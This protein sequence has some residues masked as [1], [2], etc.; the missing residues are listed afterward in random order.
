MKT[1]FLFAGAVLMLVS[2]CPLRAVW[3]PGLLG[4]TVGGNSINKTAF[5][6]E[7]NSYPNPHAGATTATPPWALFT[8]WIYWG[9]IYLPATNIWFAENIDDGI[10]MRI[11]DGATPTIILEDN[12]NH[13]TPTAGS[14]TAPVAGWYPVEIRM[15]NGVGGAGP[16]ASSG[17]TATKGFGY[18]LGGA[19]ST[20]G[21]DYTFPDGTGDILFRYDD[22]GNDV[23]QITGTPANYGVVWPPY[24]VTNGLAAGDS[25]LC[26][27]QAGKI[28]I[29]DGSRASCAG[30]QLFT[31]ETVLAASGTTNAF[32]YTHDLYARLVWQWETAYQMDFTAGAGGSLSTTGGWY[33]AGATVNVTA[34]PGEHCTFYKWIGNVPPGQ[35]QSATL[36]FTSAEPVTA[37]AVFARNFYVSPTGN[38]ALDGRTPATARA[39]LLSVY[40]DAQDGETIYILE[41]DYASLTTTNH[42]VDTGAD[43]LAVV[44]KAV[45]IAGAGPDKT[46]L[47]CH[48]D[49]RRSGGLWIANANAFVTGL[50]IRDSNNPRSNT[51]NLAYGAA[52]HLM[53]GTV[54]NCVARNNDGTG[55]NGRQASVYLRGGLF[56]H[57]A[58]TNNS[59][60]NFGK[61]AAL[62]IDGGEAA[63]CTIARNRAGDNVAANSVYL[64]SGVLRDS[65]VACN[66]G[67][68][69]YSTGQNCA[70][71]VHLVNGTLERCVIFGNTNNTPNTSQTS[72]GGLLITG[73]G[74]A[75]NCLI[76]RNYTASGIGTAA[77]GVI[78]NHNNA[79][80]VHSTVA[81]NAALTGVGGVRVVRGLLAGSVACGDRQGDVVIE[82]GGSAVHSRFGEAAPDDPDG[83]IFAS[84]LFESTGG[85]APAAAAAATAYRIGRA[86]P[87]NNA[88]PDIYDTSDD[89]IG[90]PRQDY[91][92]RT[93]GCYQVQ[94]LAAGEVEVAL[95][96]VGGL[97]TFPPG[98]AITLAASVFGEAT[99]TNHTWMISTNGTAV[100]TCQTVDATFPLPAACRAYGIYTVHLTVAFSDA[101]DAS[102]TRTDCYAV[103]PAVTYVSTTG[104]NVWPY[105]TAA[106][107]AGSVAD[108]L[109]AL[110][111]TDAI[112]GTVFIADGNYTA[113]YPQGDIRFMKLDRNIRVV[114]NESDPSR[115]RFTYEA[116]AALG[117]GVLVAHTLPPV[118]RASRSPEP[119]TP[120][121]TPSRKSA[122][123]STSRRA[124]S[125]TAS[126]PAATRPR[127]N[128]GRSPPSC[129]RAGSS[130]A[131]SSPTTSTRTT[132]P[133]TAAA[134]PASTSRAAGCAA[135]SWPAT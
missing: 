17:W 122:T 36:S 21:N 101:P 86:S 111:A 117:G 64:N 120:A 44:E 123:P 108:A 95:S 121:S 33:A 55:N 39:N 60:G 105:A 1:R 125:P 124:P 74:V 130:P 72:V 54:S 42:P 85:D 4:G 20:D 129:S 57:S 99:P 13:S 14:F 26:Q 12:N 132:H 90:F 45:R 96:V 81:D 126:S 113:V 50:T 10:Y 76:T 100:G 92:F 79:R 106:T 41:G 82:A 30:Y 71:G 5:P 62:V 19:K 133:P 61:F 47:R 93:M 15:W 53:A 88:V 16:Y 119:P 66:S 91:E 70:G 75:R 112:Q 115:V 65:V 78:L 97:D 6:A 11:W 52:F 2:A 110:Y 128:A 23:L 48:S 104:G 118:S 109:G 80:L 31:N 18:K 59:G 7:T 131:A 58:V 51:D 32:I 134:R 63:H 84:P 89:L 24:G 87:C 35:E 135:P 56:T 127:R 68:N 73:A 114:G 22:G 102:A 9:Q 25:F 3:Q 40:E 28:A 46:I 43:Y 103:K 27:A 29:A 34:T 8:T 107:A 69:S 37:T 38:D 77:G 94:P 83:N 67:D 116:P 49:A 98:E